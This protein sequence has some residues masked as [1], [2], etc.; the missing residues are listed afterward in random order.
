MPIV[1]DP[2]APVSPPFTPSEDA[3]S[4][5]ELLFESLEPLNVI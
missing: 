2:P 5:G 4:L 1:I 3:S